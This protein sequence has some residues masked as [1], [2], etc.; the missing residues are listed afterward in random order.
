MEVPDWNIDTDANHFVQSY[1]KDFID[2]SGSLLLR[3]NANLTVNGNIETNGNITVKNPIMATDLSLNHN[4]FVG[5]D[6]SMNGNVTVGDVSMNGKVVDCSF[7]DSSIPESAFNGTIPRP[8]YTQPTIIYEKG[9]ETSYDVSMNG[10]VQINNLKVDGNIEF[11]D[12]TTMNTFDDNFINKEYDYDVSLEPGDYFDL[13]SGSLN[14]YLVPGD[15]GEQIFCSSDG[16]YA[17]IGIGGGGNN[18]NT[19]NGDGNRNGI[20][21]TRDFGATWNHTHLPN[22]ADGTPLYRNH[23]A[24]QMSY[25]GKYMVCGTQASTSSNG[26][27]D[28]VIGL[29]SDYGVTWTTYDTNTQV[30]GSASHYITSI[31]VNHDASIITVCR[32]SDNTT[33]ISTDQMATWSN[34]S[35]SKEGEF[36]NTTKIVNN[37]VFIGHHD[38]GTY[39]GY[40]VDG[41]SIGSFNAVGSSSYKCNGAFPMG[42]PGGSNTIFFTNRHNG[43]IMKYTNVDTTPVAVDISTVNTSAENYTSQGVVMSPSGKYVL[44]GQNSGTQRS[45][46]RTE[47]KIYCSNDFGETFSTVSPYLFNV[48]SLKSIAISDNGYF[49]GFDLTGKKL[50]HSRFEKFKAS[51]FTSLT[52]N[53]TLTAGSFSTSSDYRIKT[54][55]SQLD[56]TVT[57]DNL[58]PVKYLQTLLNKPQYGLIAHELQEYYPDLVVGEKDGEEWQR[59]N[60][61]G[62]IALLINE[63]KQLKCELTELENGM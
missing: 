22:P 3:E 52:I 54:D 10:N 62:L 50:Y 30:G 43:N 39:L 21:I 4:M 55:I 6:I 14:L 9:F 12:G 47:Y 2:I 13:T 46:I 60:Y 18:Q 48:A 35:M 17:A 32:S 1:I 8:D 33:Q 38:V 44:I 5:G 40:D 34:T 41:T 31:A 15:K 57:L 58:R 26:G 20:F 37:R 16:R 45:T 36:M 56:E 61:T 11:S 27:T 53:N 42:G 51:T 28:T 59:V 63:I 19:G 49:Y 25:D 7:T 29:S 24:F 23:I